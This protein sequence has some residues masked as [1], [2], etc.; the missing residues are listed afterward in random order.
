MVRRRD[1]SVAR[2]VSSSVIRA[3]TGWV[4]CPVGVRVGDWVG[5][6]VAEGVALAAAVGMAWRWRW[7]ASSV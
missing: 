1:S 5:D 3:S 2:L 7:P 6:L 4:A